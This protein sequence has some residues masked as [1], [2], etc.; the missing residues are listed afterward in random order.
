MSIARLAGLA[1]RGLLP[2]A[3]VRFGI[4]RMLAERLRQ[5]GGDPEAVRAARLEFA[6]ACRKSPI[7]LVPEQANEQHYEVPASFF[8]HVLGPHLKYSCALWDGDSD[9]LGYAEARML[10]RTCERAGLADGMSVLD[11]GCGWGSLSLYAA[12]RFPA[13]QIRAVSNSCS[14]RAWIEARAAARGLHNLRVTTADVN[15]FEPSERFD[16]VV[17]VEMFE[18]V[19]NHEALLARIAGWLAP[20]GRLLAHHFCHRQMAYP[21]E[22]E[23]AGN[24]MGRHFFSGGMMPSEDWLSHFDFDLVVEAQWRV[25]GGHYAR[26]SEAWLERLD[27]RRD[28]VLPILASTYG[29]DAGRWL[30]RWRLFFLGCAE[31]FAAGGGSEW[32]VTHVRLAPRKDAG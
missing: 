5:Y 31:L 22:T 18:H 11:L 14:Q 2:D 8:E 7:A 9:S 15:H 17:S 3:L 25:P 1:E 23:G 12:E 10:E 30:Q 24:W 16:R 13:A 26:T 4:R 32:F 27:A 20:G 6:E 28:A 19:R 21:Y 29:S